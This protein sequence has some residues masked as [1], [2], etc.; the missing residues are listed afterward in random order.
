MSIDELKS[1]AYDQIAVK[2]TAENNLRM[3]N[4][5]IDKKF[6]ESQE[7]PVEASDEVEAEKVSE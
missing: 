4:A 1:M 7:A 5:Q 3:L 2:E 6:K